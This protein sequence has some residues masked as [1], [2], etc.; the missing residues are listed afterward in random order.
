MKVRIANYLC[1]GN[2]AVSGSK[3]A[4]DAVEKLGKSYK[5]RLD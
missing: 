4:C 3:E 1:P 5:V 2:Y